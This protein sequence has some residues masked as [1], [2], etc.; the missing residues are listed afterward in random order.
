MLKRNVI[1]ALFLGAFIA[2]IGLSNAYAEDE[3]KEDRIIR[4]GVLA[5]QGAKKCMSKW[6]D[7]AEYLNEQI[8][9]LSFE[10]IPLSQE[11]VYPVVGAGQVDFILVTPSIYV[12]LES[13]YQISRIASMKI[14]YSTGSYTFLGGVLFC[15]A[16]RDD[17]QNISD[18]KGK[19]LMGLHEKACTAWHAVRLELLEN[20]IEPYKDF[21]DIR[22]GVTGSSVVSAVRNNEVDVGA[23]RS[24]SYE[25]MVLS[26]LIKPS[27]FRVLH[28][29][30]KQDNNVSFVHSTR[31]FPEKPFAKVQHT[32]NELAE[33]VAAALIDMPADSLAAKSS[34]SAGW[35]I[36]HNYQS[37]HECLKSLNLSPYEDYDKVTLAKIFVQYKPWIITISMLVIIIFFAGSFIL[38]LKSKLG[39]A[40]KVILEHQITE[41]SDNAYRKFSQS[42]HD[43]L[44]QQLTR[45]KFM[46]ETLKYRLR[47]KSPK[48]STYAE[49]ISELVY[50]VINQSRGLA[51]GLNPAE[52]S[53]NDL[54][55]A[56]EVLLRNIENTFNIKCSL[57]FDH[58]IEL[59][60]D[61]IAVNLF[62]IIQEA[63]H[64]AIKHGKASKVRIS[65]AD[66]DKEYVLTIENNGK[67]LSSE[68]GHGEGMGLHIMKYRANAINAKFKISNIAEGGVQVRCSWPKSLQT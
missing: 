57:D 45:I 55:S 13:M 9:Q 67:E 25:R 23:V 54:F 2:L 43:G 39:R 47:S 10:I 20:D 33:K 53:E 34:Q 11:Q 36:P 41:I 50:E 21:V 17:I 14:I 46:A 49:Q 63:I 27:E 35:T 31:I 58:S 30:F 56:I 7:T 51:K 24:D 29:R 15:N 1:L 44:G 22:F 60:D 40:Q 16:D 59:K 4:I 65:L 62:R 6:G 37:V 26:G 68:K 8:P 52:L 42:L 64:N 5:Q 32:P 28:S 61:S 18:L 12:E 3:T 66:I 19:S 48:D 38:L